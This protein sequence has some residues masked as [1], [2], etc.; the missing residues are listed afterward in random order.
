[1]IVKGGKYLLFFR[2]NGSP[3]M[4]VLQTYDDLDIS[5]FT[6]LANRIL[7]KEYSDYNELE[8]T[9]INGNDVLDDFI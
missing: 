7:K 8:I 2:V 5:N 6:T 9:D 4:R 1:M 3:N